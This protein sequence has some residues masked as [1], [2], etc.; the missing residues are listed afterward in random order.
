MSSRT[1]SRLSSWGSWAT[2][3]T[4]TTDEVFYSAETHLSQY[5]IGC[6]ESG[7]KPSA[8]VWV[9]FF[10]TDRDRH[11]AT[12]QRLADSAEQADE[13]EWVREGR[14]NRALTP[15]GWGQEPTT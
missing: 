7:H 14:R 4:I 8:S 6:R 9:R 5:L 13:D 1:P 2:T 3:Q 12:L 11:I 15:T 10:I